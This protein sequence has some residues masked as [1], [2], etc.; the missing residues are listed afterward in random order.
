MIRTI[1]IASVAMVAMVTLTANSAD[2]QTYQTRYVISGQQESGQS[3]GCAGGA[4]VDPLASGTARSH[5]QLGFYAT[6]AYNGLRIDYVIPGSPAQRMGLERGDIV[7][8]MSSQTNPYGYATIT[9]IRSPQDYIN[10]MAFSGA[11]VRLHVQDVWGRGNVW[12]NPVSLTAGSLRFGRG[13][14]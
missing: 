12:L 9:N 5:Y 11:Q 7:L 4:C 10:V 1:L 8:Q 13:F 6:T 2:A 14:F 3:G